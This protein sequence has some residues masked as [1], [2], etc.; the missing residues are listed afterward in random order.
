MS[1]GVAQP[2]QELSR[3]FTAP[4]PVLSIKLTQ[5]DNQLENKLKAVRTLFSDLAMPSEIET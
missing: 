1:L 3:N 5:Y 4:S 2:T